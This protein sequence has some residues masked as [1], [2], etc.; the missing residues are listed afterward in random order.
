MFSTLKAVFCS[1]SVQDKPP[2]IISKPFNF[3]HEKGRLESFEGWPVDFI[4]E[5]VLAKTGFY[6]LGKEDRVQCQFCKVILHEWTKGDDEVHEHIKWS[7]R[8]PLLTRQPTSNVAFENIDYLLPS[9]VVSLDEC[10]CSPFLSEESEEEKR[11][12]K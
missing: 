3:N 7:P 8:C 10:G 1:G 4:S 2:I 5:I 9:S 6:F 12:A 11:K